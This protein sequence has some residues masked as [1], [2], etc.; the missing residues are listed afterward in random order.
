MIITPEETRQII[1]PFEETQEQAT[2]SMSLLKQGVLV[3]SN[4]ELDEQVKREK[5]ETLKIQNVSQIRQTASLL[6]QKK[7]SDKFVAL[8]QQ[9]DDSEIIKQLRTELRD[10]KERLGAIEKEQRLIREDILSG[11]A[12]ERMQRRI[13]ENQPERIK[14]K[15]EKIDHQI[16]VE[17]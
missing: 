16:K 8:L 13:L 10:M 9:T 4:N 3:I 1:T 6:N 12:K 5:L 14:E 7:E 15:K 11:Q 2:P 17:I